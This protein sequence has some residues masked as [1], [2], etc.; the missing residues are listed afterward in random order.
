MQNKRRTISLQQRRLRLWGWLFLTP[1]LILFGFIVAYP[2]LYSLWLGL[3]DWQV[4]GDKTFIGLGN[5]NRM[6]R[7]S[8]LWTSL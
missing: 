7:D 8:L 6:F 2:L 1:A 4:L 5:Y 3:F